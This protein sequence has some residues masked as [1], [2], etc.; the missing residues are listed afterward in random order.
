MDT[1]MMAIK[2][3]GDHLTKRRLVSAEVNGVLGEYDHRFEFL[4]SGQFAI[5]YGPNG[6]GKTRVLEIINAI[7]NVNVLKLRS[8]PFTAADL[9]F[10]DGS[11]LRV[12]RA[13]RST[14]DDEL[15]IEGLP[16]IEKP[17]ELLLSLWQGDSL[18]AESLVATLDAFQEHLQKMTRYEPT[19]DFDTWIDT[20]DGETI[21]YDVLRRRYLPQFRAR[22][23]TRR[24]GTRYTEIAPEL[25]DFTDSLDVRLIE[26][27]RLGGVYYPQRSRD[28]ES[29]SY[30]KTSPDNVPTIIRWS[31]QIKQSLNENL[32]ANS[33]LTQSL[34]STFPRRMLERGD[35]SELTEE[36]LRTKWE[37]QTK[38]RARLKKIAVLDVDAQL[39]LPNS[40]LNPWQLGML[41]LYLEDADKKLDS[42]SDILRRINLLEEIVNARLL[43]K[44]IRIDANNGLVVI[45]DL[46][47]STI[48]LTSLSSGEQHE[49]ILMFD[50]LFNVRHGSL[51]MID[52]PEI[53]L[54]IGWQ[55]KFIE[56]VIRI[57]NIVGFQFVVA[58]HSPQIIDRW[59]ANATRLGP[60]K[61]G[62]LE[63][64]TAD[65]AQ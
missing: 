46:D 24:G 40:S 43:R 15:A 56:D 20:V 25:Q 14:T 9:T 52:E 61:G 37:E 51:V 41:E 31:E 34:D 47:D 18:V 44:N 55:K 10:S 11:R 58:T 5:V 65:D 64:E 50:L 59:W 60:T 29:N 17:G 32:S 23:P 57:S 13:N 42:F 27:Q 62:F 49:I 39:S 63:E 45:R 21:P 35:K 26:T 4:D 54:H 28:R 38:R 33:R 6:V 16:E 53:S 8:L 12:E 2:A 3:Q 1:T 19:N 30:S 7:A 22:Y 48:P 36:E